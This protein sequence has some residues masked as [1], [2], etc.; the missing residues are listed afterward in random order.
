MQRK[1]RAL[2]RFTLIFLGALFVASVCQ[3]A[4]HEGSKES[5]DMAVKAIDAFIEQQKIDKSSPSWKGDLT[6]PPKVK[7]DPSHSYFWHLD[8]NVGNV[9]IKL[10][11]DTAPMHVASTIYLTRLGF[12]DELIFHRVITGFMAQGGDPT[13]SGTGGPGYKYDGEYDSKVKHDK[14]GMLSAANTGRPG[15]DGSQF[16]LTFAATP[17]LDGKHTVYGEVSEG[18]GTVKEL[19][20]YA[21]PAP[22][23]RPT[24]DLLIEK[25]NITVE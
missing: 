22:Q 1:P 8:T 2:V 19:E 5:K 21:G 13:G 14:P 24:K 15:T 12:Y 17:W 25:A 4:G 16:F 7:F 3:A 10:L 23:N 6:K 18:M 11:Q 20:K 9:K